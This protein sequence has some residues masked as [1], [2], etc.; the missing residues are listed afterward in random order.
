MI[1]SFISMGA[2]NHQLRQIF[3]YQASFIA[4]LGI[5]IGAI[6]GLGLCFLQ[7]HFQFIHL[8]ESA[9]FISTLPI[10]IKWD[11]VLYV[12]LG[13]AV[14]SYASFMLPSLWIKKI[15]PSRAI[16]FQ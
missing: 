9:Y 3:L 13:T 11:E 16:R 14:I 2:T 1:G 6:L 7:I 4:W 5:G 15:N 10:Y 12:I 8:D